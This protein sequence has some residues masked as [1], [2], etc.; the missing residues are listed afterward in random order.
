MWKLDVP[1]RP[2][3]QVMRLMGLPNDISNTALIKQNIQ[4]TVLDLQPLVDFIG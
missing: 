1:M 3:I 2:Q 4:Q